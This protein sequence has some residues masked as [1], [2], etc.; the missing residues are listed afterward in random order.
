M[1]NRSDFWNVETKCVFRSDED[2]IRGEGVAE[3]DVFALTG[4]GRVSLRCLGW[5]GSC[6][7]CLK[8]V[9]FESSQPESTSG[10]VSAPS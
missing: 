1:L 3:E 8:T 2:A 9:R 7:P 4:N 6:S 5:T 10:E